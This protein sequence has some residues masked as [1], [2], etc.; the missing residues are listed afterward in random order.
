[1]GRNGRAW[2]GFGPLFIY[3]AIALAPWEPVMPGLGLDHSWALV[4]SES[5]GTGSQWGR[6]LIFTSGPY[7]FMYTGIHNPDLYVASLV[8]VVCLIAAFCFALFYSWNRVGLIVGACAGVLL[9][10]SVMHAIDALFYT[11]PLV[12]L[13]AYYRKPASSRLVYCLPLV[14]ATGL[15]SLVK[16][17]FFVPAFLTYLFLDWARAWRGLFPLFAPVFLNSVVLFYLLAGQELRWLPEFVFFSWEIMRG[18]G[19]AMSLSG[20]LGELIL[21]VGC[22][23]ALVVLVVR[24]ESRRLKVHGAPEESMVMILSLI[25]VTWVALKAGFVRHDLHSVLAWM[26]LGAVSALCGVR[27]YGL[28]AKRR[29][30]IGIFSLSFLS[31]A[32]GLTV[33]GKSGGEAPI[34]HLANSGIKE[35]YSNLLKAVAL[36]RNPAGRADELDAQRALAMSRI[37][38]QIPVPQPNGTVDVIPNVQSAVLA[39]NLNYRPRPVFQGYAAYTAPLAKANHTFFGGANAPEY[40]IFDVVSIDNRY[41][42]LTE[43]RLWMELMQ[44][45][46]PEEVVGR[47]LLFHRRAE[48]RMDMLEGVAV[49]RQVGLGET[50]LVP[51]FAAA[52]FV[53]IDMAKTLVGDLAGILFK[54]PIVMIKVGLADGSER[55]FRFIPE[56]GRSGFLLSPLIESGVEFRAFVEGNG[57]ELHGKRV[58]SVRF[59]LRHP[60]LA[61]AFDEMINVRFTPLYL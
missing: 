15:L 54:S 46:E 16:I 6:D 11:L 41:P 29:L 57:K 59:E 9:T 7:G 24:I 5:G 23:A 13:I 35:P 17:S 12:L 18:Y 10:I 36:I 31:I 32:V 2:L 52:W 60:G 50:V 47:Y 40:V 20:D 42:S 3:L 27:A 45:Y 21:F 43:G 44:R 37:R 39:H 19:D 56:M 25:V 51:S 8:L 26:T 61:I 4:V 49:S 28:L 33:L 53:E 30:I 14:V 34:P 1:M 55:T 38:E 58:A 22:V 48:F